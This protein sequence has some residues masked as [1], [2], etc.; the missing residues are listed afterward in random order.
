[1]KSFIFIAALF[2]A[3]NLFS[4]TKPQVWTMNTKTKMTTDKSCWHVYYGDGVTDFNKDIITFI[5]SKT[6]YQVF[7]K[8]GKH[9]DGSPIW[10]DYTTGKE[11]I[12]VVEGDKVKFLVSEKKMYY[13]YTTTEKTL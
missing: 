6:K 5:E 12:R 10:W 1:M 3:T 11:V 8:E 9:N 2:A 13:Y 4:Q 7:Y